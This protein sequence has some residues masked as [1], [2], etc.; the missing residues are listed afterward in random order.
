MFHSSKSGHLLGYVSESPGQHYFRFFCP[1]SGEDDLLVLRWYRDVQTFKEV[2]RDCD[3]Q[4][5]LKITVLVTIHK[6]YLKCFFRIQILEH[7]SKAGESESLGMGL[8]KPYF[9]KRFR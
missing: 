3:G 8:R 7:F 4:L 1:T 2:S 6:N 9:R 5:L